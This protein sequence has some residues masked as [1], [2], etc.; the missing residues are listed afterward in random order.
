MLR[1]KQDHRL[2]DPHKAGR[3][4]YV[5]IISFESAETDLDRQALSRS[6][7]CQSGKKSFLRRSKTQALLLQSKASK[8]DSLR[9]ELS[10]F[11]VIMMQKDDAYGFSLRVLAGKGKC[12]VYVHVFLQ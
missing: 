1:Q 9:A 7:V 5:A 8:L 12:L 3:Q 4:A 10:N 2:R 11:L 6:Q